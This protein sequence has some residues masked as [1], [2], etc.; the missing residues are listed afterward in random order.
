MD[1]NLLDD[2]VRAALA[3]GADAAEAVLAERQSLS[4]NVRNQKLEEVER[5]EARDLGLRVFVGQQQ[6]SVSGSDLSADARARL[7]E[8]VVAMAR[9][10]PPD[11]YAGLAPADRLARDPD[12]DL[13]LF[14]ATEPSAETLEDQARRA[15]EAARAV[16]GVTNS[17]GGAA[18]W[19][20]SHWRFV[21]SGG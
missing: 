3:A 21:T 17:D 9:L 19:A 2:V 13:D 4:V 20:A 10:A 7:I 6:A 1:E 15:E 11:P 8:R 16:E 5:E 14:D 18:A 12:R